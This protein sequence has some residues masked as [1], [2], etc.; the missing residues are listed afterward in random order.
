MML[1]NDIISI[2][3]FRPKIIKLN[4]DEAPDYVGV[5]GN[6]GTAPFILNFGIRWRWVVSFLQDKTAPG[7]NSVFQICM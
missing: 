6:K 5:W 7:A 2:T 3:H 1:F 4:A